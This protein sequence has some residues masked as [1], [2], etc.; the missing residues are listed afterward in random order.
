MGYRVLAVFLV[1]ALVAACFFP[2]YIRRRHDNPLNLYTQAE[3]LY[4]HAQRSTP[5]NVEDLRNSKRLLD[6]ACA[7]L[8]EDRESGSVDEHVDQDVRQL[9]V[10]VRRA[11][12][13]AE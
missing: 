11:L 2:R 13:E 4:A 9:L 5:W 3:E 10:A 7:R 1:L 8:D 12:V 6:K